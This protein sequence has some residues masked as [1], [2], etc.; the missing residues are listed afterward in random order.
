MDERSELNVRIAARGCDHTRTIQH[1]LD[2]GLA[3]SGADQAG[4]TETFKWK[5]VPGGRTA[6]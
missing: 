1:G 3:E 5:L 6:A 4:S 2:L